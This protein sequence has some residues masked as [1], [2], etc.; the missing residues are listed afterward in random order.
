MLV[1]GQMATSR[2]LV[3]LLG[4][5]ERSIRASTSSTKNIEKVQWYGRVAKFIRE[6]GA[7]ISRME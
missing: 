5:L 6:V 7:I 2:E 4:H 1:S 3:S